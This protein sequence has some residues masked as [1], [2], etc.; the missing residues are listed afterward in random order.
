MQTA[1]KLRICSSW[2]TELKSVP[3]SISNSFYI[4]PAYAKEIENEISQLS[5]SKPSGPFSSILKLLKTT[6]SKPLELIYNLSFSTGIVPDSFK[7]ARVIPIYKKGSHISMGNYHSI[8]LLS[9]F[10]KIQEKL[11]CKRLVNFLEKFNILYKDQLFGFRPKHSTI[12]AILLMTDK[13]QMAIEDGKFSCGI[14]S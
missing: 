12:H 8:S 10:N 13:I 3:A 7:I 14:F 9:I 1:C 4:F 2:Y 6:L 5:S 11:M